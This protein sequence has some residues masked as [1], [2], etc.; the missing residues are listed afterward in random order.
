MIKKVTSS[1]LSA[2]VTTMEYDLKQASEMQGGI[3]MNMC[4]MWVLHFKME[5]VQPLILQIVTG[6]LQL[7]YCPLFQIYVS[8]SLLT[9][10]IMQSP[11]KHLLFDRSWEG[12]WSVHSKLS[13]PLVKIQTQPYVKN[14]SI[15][16]T[17]DH[18]STVSR[19]KMHVCGSFMMWLPD[20]T[21]LE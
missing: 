19:S 1:F 6:L 11:S 8:L 17:P 14:V 20:W 21:R 13:H 10:R 5:K 18:S 7:V 12:I 15:M 9:W 2:E 3:L 4:F 16:K